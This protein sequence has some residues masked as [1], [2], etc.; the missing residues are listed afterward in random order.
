MFSHRQSLG[1]DERITRI[2]GTVAQSCAAA[3]IAIALLSLAGWTT[4]RLILDRFHAD[5]MPMAPTAA[6]AF[7]LLGGA[8]LGGTTLEEV[9]RV[10][11]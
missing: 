4:G 11:R 7:L 5:F 6:L 3:T 8:L 2:L 9:F 1:C 10:A